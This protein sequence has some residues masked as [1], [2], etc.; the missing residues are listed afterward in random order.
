M[1]Q[2]NLIAGA[3]GQQGGFYSYE[4]E[5]SL[6][7]NDDDS[8]YLSQTPSVT[9]NQKKWT[10]SAWVK[11]GNLGTTQ[12]IFSGDSYSGNDGIAALYFYS[13]DT[14][15]S[16]YDTSGTNPSGAIGPRV[17]RDAS[18]W[19]HIIWAVDAVNTEHKI[20]VNNELVS[21]D[22]S[23]YPPDFAY[24]VNR[25]GTSMGIGV[26]IWTPAAYFDGYMA[27]VNFVDGEYLT[28]TSFGEFKSDIWVPKAYSGSYGTN[29]F[30]L[31]FSDGAAIGDDLSGNTNDWTANNL[32][33]TD[34]VLDSPTNNFAT[35][36][37][38]ASNMST[39]SLSEGNL[40]N[41]T[42]RAVKRTNFAVSSGKWYMEARLVSDTN[43][44]SLGLIGICDIGQ[45]FASDP[46]IS[47]KHVSYYGQNGNK[48]INQTASAYGAT[49]AIGDI[50][51]VALD[52][53]A[54]DVEFFKNNVSQGSIS[55]STADVE[56]AVLFF[57][58]GGN[59]YAPVFQCNF[60]QDGSFSGTATA[61]GNTDAN[62]QGDFYYAPPSGFLA[63][64]TANLPTPAIDPAQ[65]DVSADYFNTVLYTGDGTSSHAITGVGFQPDFT[66]IK[67]RNQTGWH[68][69]SDAIRGP[70]ALLFSNDTSAEDTTAGN[71]LSFD[72]DGFTVGSD[73]S[74][75]GNT[76]TYVAWNWLAGNGTTSNTDGTIT[77]T[78]SVNQKAG[79]SIVS[80]VNASS[81]NQETVGHGLGSAPKL[82]IAKNRDTSANNWAVFHSSVCDTTSKFLRLN[83]TDSL[84]TFST[85][86]GA[87]LPTSSVFGVTGGGIAAASVNMIAYCFAEV[88]GFSKFGSYTGNGS[89]DGPFVYCGFRPAF[90]MVKRTDNSNNWI[91]WDTTRNT[92]NQ[93][94][95]NLYPDTSAAENND[96]GID[97]LSN[98]F[99]IR[100]TALFS[101]ASGGTYIFMAFAE[102][103][104]KYSNAR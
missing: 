49:F 102:A 83:T 59:S 57:S 58:S 50:I 20:W 23:K 46:F 84:V 30:Y 73:G 10:F 72:T 22:A 13:D 44:P 21:T 70:N 33:A 26:N 51:G 96:P 39:G 62:G 8:A 15:H 61:Q 76:D 25:N 34:V 24:G 43:T 17:Y 4:I 101:N 78:V 97:A 9:S 87:A 3:A 104:F 47:L 103:P 11:R 85:V 7:F 99:K 55:L 63:L 79:F 90:V 82:I 80:F 65:D 35:L 88:E 93:I 81:T 14:L 64:N 89:A 37:P 36:S 94:D 86:W 16:Y 18:A 19:Y 48:Y 66:W 56:E 42:R 40:R 54:G 98:G 67:E 100:G 69:L 1:F 29:G 91:L 31:P 41:D 68:R 77:S 60:G 45:P 2:N 12:G 52:M 71:F 95:D 28:P 6:R 32:A 75:N 38:I 53:D 27:E 92:Y 74:I 5:Q